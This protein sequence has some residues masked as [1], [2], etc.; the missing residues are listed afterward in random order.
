MRRE[1]DPSR[2]THALHRRDGC[3]LRGTY[4]RTGRK[5]RRGD[6]GDSPTKLSSAPVPLAQIRESVDY[7]RATYDISESEAVR[8]LMLQ[9]NMTAMTDWLA[10]TYPDDYAGAWLDQEHG[11]T[12]VVAATRPERI[13]A[14]VAALPDHSFIKTQAARYSLRDLQLA[15]QRAAGYIG[16]DAYR[17][18]LTRLE[19]RPLSECTGTMRRRRHKRPLPPR[20]RRTEPLERCAWPPSPKP[21]SRTCA[22]H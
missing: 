19:T 21:C 11:G 20:C 2:L 22:T 4:D 6:P 5:R 17:R 16:G 13:A 15:G 9:Q 10:G 1:H 8:R 3:G 12:M 7:L 14:A 18:P